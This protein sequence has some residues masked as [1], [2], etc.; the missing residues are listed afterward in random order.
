MAVGGSTHTDVRVSYS[1]YGPELDFLTPTLAGSSQGSGGGIYTTDRTGT[2][3]YSSTDYYSN[4]SG[5][6]SATPLAAGIGACAVPQPQ[7]DGR[8][9]T[10]PVA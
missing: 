4:F 8:P 9:V 1:Q 10:R 6:S 7:P 3:G 2:S 5:T